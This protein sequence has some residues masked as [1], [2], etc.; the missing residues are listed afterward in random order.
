MYRKLPHG[1]RT[2]PAGTPTDLFMWQQFLSEP[3]CRAT[4]GTRPTVLNLPRSR[5][6]DQTPADRLIELEGWSR[7]LQD[8]G[9][10]D[11]F[12]LRVLD[13][14]VRAR[15]GEAMRLHAEIEAHA[16]A[17]AR[18]RASV[19]AQQQNVGRLRAL[20]RAR[21]HRIGE[22]NRRVQQLEDTVK[23]IQ[24]SRSW[25]LLTALG[26]VRSRIPSRGG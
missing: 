14:A 16:H 26:H 5:R 19:E 2:T 17:R 6:R 8:P 18:L 4:G 13:E 21:D 15:A 1:W 12:A 20:L 11:A 7:D 3:G 24:S 9:W 22:L 25:R 23:A 10:R